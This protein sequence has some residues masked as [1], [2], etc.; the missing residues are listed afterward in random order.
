[1]ARRRLLQFAPAL[2]LFRAVPDFGNVFNVRDFGARGDGTNIDTAP[3]NRAIAA[4]AASG[5]GTVLLPPGTY[6]SYSI[7]LLSRITLHLA[8]G[9]TLL[10]ATPGTRAGDRFDPP[11]PVSHWARYQDFGHDHW[12]DSLIWGEGLNDVT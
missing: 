8:R 1:M 12:H 5:G 3:I 10:A 9:A 7:R 6:A 11:E 2:V 4:A